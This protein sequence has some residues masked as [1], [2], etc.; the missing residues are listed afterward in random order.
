M[1]GINY[2]LK[3]CAMWLL[4][5]PRLLTGITWCTNT[6]LVWPDHLFIYIE[7]EKMQD[8]HYTYYK[9][10]GPCMAGVHLDKVINHHALTIGPLLYSMHHS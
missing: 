10:R 6:R 3:P 2:G 4:S 8:T 7:T 5:E 9:Q 1:Q